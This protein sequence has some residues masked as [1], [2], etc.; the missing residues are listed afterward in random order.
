MINK[1]MG[2]LAIGILQY[3]NMLECL[4]ASFYD[5]PDNSWQIYM[6]LL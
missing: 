1:I 3:T 2:L 4:E 6:Q 5:T